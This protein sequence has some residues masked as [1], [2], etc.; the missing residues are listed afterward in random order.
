MHYYTALYSNTHVGLSTQ[1]ILR[2]PTSGTKCEVLYT[3]L[4]Y[5]VPKD[6]TELNSFAQQSNL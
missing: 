5:W 2:N 6:P 3:E 1:V 4:A